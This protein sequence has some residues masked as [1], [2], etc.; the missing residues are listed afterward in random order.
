MSDS[1]VTD[2]PDQPE[3]MIDIESLGAKPGACIV[4]IGAVRFTRSA[5]IG[6]EFFES[7]NVADAQD[8]GL[9][10][11]AGTVTWWLT[12]PSE[13]R[14]QLD[15]GVLLDTA[16]RRLADFIPDNATIW[17]NS[18]AFDCVLLQSAY[19][20]VGRDCPWN[21]Y[22]Q[23]DYRTLRNELGFEEDDGV[24]G[25]KHNAL[26]DAR[27]QTRALLGALGEDGWDGDGDGDDGV[28]GGADE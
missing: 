11:D 24:A 2:D 1:I 16:L 12:Q 28:G 23:E 5:G 19:R 8:Q 3:I 21:Y 4:S 15:G 9:E 6:E 13:A 22:Q 14:G 7:V 10:V 25:V 20:A 26:A 17:A 18:P 27:R